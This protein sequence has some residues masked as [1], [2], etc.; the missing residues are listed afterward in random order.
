M[1]QAKYSIEQLLLLPIIMPSSHLCSW[2]GIYIKLYCSLILVFFILFVFQPGVTSTV[3]LVFLQEKSIEVQLIY[4]VLI[5]AYSKV[6]QLYIYPLFFQILFPYRLLQSIKQNSLCYTVGPY[7]LS[8]IQSYV[9]VNPQVLIYS[10]TS[11][12]PLLTISLL[13]SCFVSK[14]ICTI[15]IKKMWYIYTV[16]IT[17]P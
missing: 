14:F 5:Q 4:N 12:L 8:Y 10:S 7:Q 1:N 11:V 13:Y 16:N 6:N 2:S 9:Y 17:L 3:H 15:W